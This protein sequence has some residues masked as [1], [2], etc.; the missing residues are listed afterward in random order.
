[1]KIELFTNKTVKQCTTELNARFEEKETKSRPAVGGYVEKGGSFMLTT[2]GR[3]LFLNRV[4]RL[5]G[6]LTKEKDLTLIQGYVSDGVPTEKVGIIML[7]LGFVALTMLLKGQAIFAILVGAVAVGA[8]ITLIGDYTNSSY[9]LKELKRITGA[10]D[11]P[12]VVGAVVAKT[13]PKNTTG[14]V[15][16]QSAKTTTVK[17]PAVGAKPST[18][19]KTAT[20]IK[21]TASASSA[22]AGGKPTPKP[23]PAKKT[24]S[25]K[26]GALPLG[27]RQK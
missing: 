10:K 6:T 4:T 15:T 2:T 13:S 5:K 22:K 24:A 17:K 20:P 11:K 7:A 16:A 14:R 27:L 19:S 1:M 12:P 8:Y 9:L 25:G 23:A 3:V 18:A 21:K 26:S